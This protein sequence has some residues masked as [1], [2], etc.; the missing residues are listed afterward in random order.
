MQ[1]TNNAILFIQ[2]VKTPDGKVSGRG[3]VVSVL[4]EG[5]V[6]DESFPLEGSIDDNQIS[7]KSNVFLGWGPT[8]SGT[9]DGEMLILVSETGQWKL[10]KSD[11]N[12]F[13]QEK[14][15]LASTGAA[16]LNA[17]QKAKQKADVEGYVDRLISDGQ[18]LEVNLSKLPQLESEADNFISQTRQKR[19][20]IVRQIKVLSVC[21][22]TC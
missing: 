4:S 5:N 7:L 15:K 1:K 22:G 16:I 17:N 20:K 9:V 13:A 14:S 3:E 2:I 21:P 18:S 12:S 19:D 6:K 11:L 10:F 8:L